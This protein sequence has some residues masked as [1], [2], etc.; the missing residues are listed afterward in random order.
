M[1]LFQP[2]HIYPSRYPLVIPKKLAIEK[3]VYQGGGAISPLLWG[4]R[5][6]A[7]FLHTTK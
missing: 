7:K 1:S 4:L 3:H 6:A 2:L 5:S